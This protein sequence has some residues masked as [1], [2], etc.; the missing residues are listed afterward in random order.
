MNSDLRRWRRSYRYLA[1]GAGEEEI[2]QSSTSDLQAAHRLMEPCKAKPPAFELELP[3]EKISSLLSEGTY[4]SYF[5]K[6]ILDEAL[7]YARVCRELAVRTESDHP[8]LALALLASALL[9]HSSFLAFENHEAYMSWWDRTSQQVDGLG[10]EVI[11]LARELQNLSGQAGQS[12]QGYE[13]DLLLRFVERSSEYALCQGLLQAAFAIREKQDAWNFR[14]K[15]SKLALEERLGHRE[16]AQELRGECLDLLRNNDDLLSVVLDQ[17]ID[18]AVIP[19]PA[20]VPA[21]APMTEQIEMALTRVLDSGLE[22]LLKSMHESLQISHALHDRLDS[23]VEKLIDL[24]QRSELTW[25]QVRDLA[26]KGAD[27]GQV[28]RAIENSLSS[29]LGDTW[30]SL[31]PASRRDLVDA[32]Y[33]YQQCSEWGTG[34]RMAVLG[35]CTTVER[36]LKAGYTAIRGAFTVSEGESGSLDNTLGGLVQAIEKLAAWL[37]KTKPLPVPWRALFGSIDVLRDMNAV[38]IR[39]AHP[40]DKEV[41]RDEATWVRQVLVGG[42]SSSLLSNIVAVHAK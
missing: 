27:Y 31:K 16:E 6:V 23:V 21:T 33:V 10:P 26:H 38:R 41:S 22:P 24:D 34:W 9:T 15:A 12:N 2:T 32:E 17:A 30:L 13:D 4:F 28:R 7:R 11:K 5:D 20:P 19:S 14:I 18:R 39:A 37:P 40:K 42:D 3:M 8:E 25:R 36:E 1:F 29:Q 35:Y